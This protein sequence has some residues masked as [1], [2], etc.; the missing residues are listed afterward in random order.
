MTG[1][2]DNRLVVGE[3]RG[4]YGVRGWVKLFSWTSPKE[5]LLQYDVFEDASGKRWR[6]LEG[7]PHGKTLIGRFE[8]VDDR[9]AAAELHGTTLYVPR[10]SL[11][12][13]E[14]GEYYWADI[15][16]CEVFNTAGN[17]FGRVSYLLE[18]GAHDVMAVTSDDG[19]ETLMPFA[20]GRTVITVDI[21]AKRITVDWAF[22]EAPL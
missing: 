8:N 11:P 6:L 7:K 16:G 18:T 4:V 12:P 3:I 21:D 1:E 15:E 19:A 17:R 13:A 10:E 20:P 9:D 5:K 2:R 14:E 22:S